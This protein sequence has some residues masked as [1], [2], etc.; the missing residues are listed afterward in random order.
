MDGKADT[1]NQVK[2]VDTEWLIRIWVFWS[3]PDPGMFLSNPN[4]AVLVG[5]GSRR[6][7]GSRSWCS[8]RIRIREFWSNQNPSFLVGS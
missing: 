7:F 8:G 5:T 3:D 6:F 4:P 2:L 1:Y